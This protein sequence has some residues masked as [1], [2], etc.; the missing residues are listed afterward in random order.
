MPSSK[1]DIATDITGSEQLWRPPQAWT[2]H[3]S[4]A[5][6]KG[7]SLTTELLTAYDFLSV[8][9]PKLLNVPQ[10]K[11]PIHKSR[12]WTFKGGRDNENTMEIKGRKYNQNTLYTFIYEENSHRKI[13]KKVNIL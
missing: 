11:T 10:T 13:N 2:R 7:L 12:K 8:V 5:W 3:N 1:K 4:E 9:C 6:V